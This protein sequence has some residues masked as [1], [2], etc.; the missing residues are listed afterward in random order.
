MAGSSPHQVESANV[1]QPDDFLELGNKAVY[2]PSTQVEAVFKGKVMYPTSEMM[3]KP[4][5]KRLMT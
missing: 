4:C 3:I 5:N 2:I 1:H